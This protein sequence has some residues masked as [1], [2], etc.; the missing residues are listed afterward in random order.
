MNSAINVKANEITSTVINT[1]NENTDTKLTEYPKT[2]TIGTLITQNTEA[3]KLAWN[4]ISEFIQLMIVNNNASFAILDNSGKKLMTLDKKGQHFYE[5][6]GNTI[7]GDIGVSVDINDNNKQYLSFATTM[8]YD[9]F[10]DTGMA[11]GIKTKIDNKFHP[12]MY[13]K[14]YDMPQYGSPYGQL[15]FSGCEIGRAHV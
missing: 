7:L 4:Q 2:T 10:L 8:D 5:T 12:I 14:N 3:V 15:V 1:A 11:W 13:L 6:D 9:E